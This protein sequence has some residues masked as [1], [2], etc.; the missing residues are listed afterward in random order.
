MAMLEEWVLPRPVSDSLVVQ[1]EQAVHDVI[2]E[3][4]EPTIVREGPFVYVTVR[5]A[6]DDLCAL[7]EWLDQ[8]LHHFDG[9]DWEDELD[10]LDDEDEPY[11][12][13]VELV[14]KAPETFTPLDAQELPILSVYSKDGNNHAAWPVA[15]VFAARLAKELG[16]VEPDAYSKPAS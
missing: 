13:R 9:W 16:A 15:F 8:P 4:F 7:A 14:N 10:A 5:A 11:L 6:F 1:L 12:L 2:D 3:S